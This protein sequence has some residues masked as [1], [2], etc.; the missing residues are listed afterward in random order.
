MSDN[1]LPSA[2]R[3]I[4]R[5]LA[6]RI[7]ELACRPIEQEKRELWYRHNALEAT[8]PLI[9]CDPENGWHEIITP[10]HLECADPMAREWEWN[11]RRLIFWGE[12]MGDDRV[13]EARFDL[14]YVSTDT[15]WGV[16]MERRHKA[17]GGSYTW[18]PPIKTCEDLKKLR[19]PEIRV[20]Y[21]ETERRR[22]LAGEIFG[23]LLEIRLC[24]SWWWSLGMT[25]LL[26]LLRGIGQVMIDMIEEPEILHSLMAFLR[27]AHMAKLDFLESS[28]LLSANHDGAYVGSGGFGYTRELPQPDFDGCHYRAGDL[29]GF[30]ESQETALV[31][32]AMFEEFVYPYQ[33]P[34]LERFG[35]NCYGC[36]EPLHLRWHVVKNFPRLRRISVSP[37]ADLQA[38]AEN[39]GGRYVFSMKPNPA[40]LAQSR[41]DESFIRGNL[42]QAL[43]ITRG[44]RLEIVMKDNHTIGR[45]PQNVI[46]WT[47]IA[48]E[49][50]ERIG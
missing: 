17:E 47:A 21:A 24:G 7:A 36:C 30:A 4:L 35:L 23:D 20:N 8:R 6:G 16:P 5:R 31:S 42:R 44:C 29:W 50:A 48:L 26:V 43:E 28:H 32:P 1:I 40:H 18:D 3:I 34:L 37:W 25:E 45:N 11:L 12:S 19:V 46:R 2:D 49:E 14:G 27:D 41:I 15:G 9:F 33:L 38:M 22:S 13:T 10:D 39:L